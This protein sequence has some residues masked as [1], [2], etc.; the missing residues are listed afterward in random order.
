MD[1]WVSCRLL[2]G[3]RRQ[4]QQSWEA[5]ISPPGG[6]RQPS[7]RACRHES[8]QTLEDSEGQGILV[9]CS[10]WG[11]NNKTRACS[12]GIGLPQAKQLTGR[13][14]SRHWVKN[15]LSVALCT[16]ARPGFPLSQSLPSGSLHEPLILIYQTE[17]A[18]TTIHR[19]QNES[20]NHRK[21]TKIITW[22]TALSNPKKL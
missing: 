18:R 22:I 7:H 19:L 17:E 1:A 13:E 4:Q 21:L 9:C 20:Y 16:R 2:Q 8:E 6:C 5:G 10:P 3:Q 15:L 12:P 14:H 11:L